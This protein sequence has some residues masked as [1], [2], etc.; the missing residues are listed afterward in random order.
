MKNHIFI[1]GLSL[2]LILSIF[3]CIQQE[4]TTPDVIPKEEINLQKLS[5]EFNIELSTNTKELKQ[6]DISLSGNTFKA[7]LEPVKTFTKLSPAFENMG[8][9]LKTNEFYGFDGGL[10][11]TKEEYKTGYLLGDI[12]IVSEFKKAP[13]DVVYLDTPNAK[14]VVKHSIKIKNNAETIEEISVD[15]EYE[16]QNAKKIIWNNDE[17]I[18]KQGEIIEFNASQNEDAK[19]N[20]I[21]EN[22]D[23]AVIDFID[24]KL[25]KHKAKISY[26]GQ[27]AVI[28]LEVSAVVNPNSEYIIDPYLSYIPYSDIL[29]SQKQGVNFIEIGD[30]NDDNKNDLIL[31]YNNKIEIYYDYLNDIINIDKEFYFNDDSSTILSLDYE[32][33]LLSVGIFPTGVYSFNP[34]E[35]SSTYINKNNAEIDLFDAIGNNFYSSKIKNNLYFASV[36]ISEQKGG[37]LFIS[38]V[39]DF[40]KS[41]IYYSELLGSKT[42]NTEITCN[43]EICCF[44]ISYKGEVYC[45]YNQDII[46]DNQ[47]K[48]YNEAAFLSF[49]GETNLGQQVL[50]NQNNLIL[51]SQD[52]VH[53][54]KDI[55]LLAGNYDI[56]DISLTTYGPKN[57]GKKIIFD[58]FNS[59]LLVLS[60]SGL[61]LLDENDFG[62]INNNPKYNTE[63]LLD[64]IAIAEN[65]N[66]ATYSGEVI[67]LGS[68]FPTLYSSMGVPGSITNCDPSISTTSGLYTLLN[69]VSII[70]AT[71]F[72]FSGYSSSLFIF[73]CDGHTISVDGDGISAIKANNAG[74]FTIQNCNFIVDGSNSNAVDMNSI[75]SLIINNCNFSIQNGGYSD[76]I[77]AVGP[78]TSISTLEAQELNLNLINLQHSNGIN[79]HQTRDININNFNISF[80]SCIDT[81]GLGIDTPS[82]IILENS[83]LNTIGL[84]NE[85]IAGYSIIG[86]SSIE[87]LDVNMNLIG[88]GITGTGFSNSNNILLN[89]SKIEVQGVALSGINIKQGSNNLVNNTNSSAVSNMFVVNV[90]STTTLNPFVISALVNEVVVDGKYNWLYSLNSKNSYD[91]KLQN[92]RFYADCPAPV[93]GSSSGGSVLPWAGYN[94]MAV[95]LN[96]SYIMN[97]TDNII[98][99][100]YCVALTSESSTGKIFNNTIERYSDD[101][102]DFDSQIY[103]P[104]N[105]PQLSAFPII[106][107]Y[108]ISGENLIVYDNEITSSLI[109]VTL[110]SKI[111][112]YNFNFSNNK[113]SNCPAFGF[114]TNVLGN[115]FGPF[116][117]F[118]SNVI[119]SNGIYDIYGVNKSVLTNF[120]TTTCTNY[121][122]LLEGGFGNCNILCY[123][124]PDILNFNLT[125]NCTD[126]VNTNFAGEQTE[127]GDPTQT[128]PSIYSNDTI[129]L[130]TNVTNPSPHDTIALMPCYDLGTN[131]LDLLNT[132]SEALTLPVVPMIG[133]PSIPSV[134]LPS[135][136]TGIIDASTDYLE[137][138]HYYQCFVYLDPQYPIPG[139]E[140]P[141]ESLAFFVENMAPTISVNPTI[142]ESPTGLF[143]DVSSSIASFIDPDGDSVGIP[144]NYTWYINGIED[145][146]TSNFLS[147][148]NYSPGDTITCS[149]SIPDDSNCPQLYSNE[150]N[151]TYFIPAQGWVHVN[152]YP[153]GYTDD[154]YYCDYEYQMPLARQYNIE[155]TWYLFDSWSTGWSSATLIDT[156]TFVSTDTFAHSNANTI[157]DYDLEKC[158]YVACKVNITNLD[159]SYIDYSLAGNSTMAET[160]S[161]IAG[162]GA[163]T[164]I[165]NRPPTL[166]G[167]LTIDTFSTSPDLVLYCNDDLVLFN[168]LDYN[169]VESSRTF[170]WEKDGVL[171][172]ETTDTLTTSIPLDE[173]TYKCCIE[174]SDSIVNG[175]C[176]DSV[177]IC[178]TTYIPPRTI[179]FDVNLSADPIVDHLPSPS[180]CGPINYGDS[181]TDNCAYEDSNFTCTVEN[182]E[183]T[184]LGRVE[185]KDVKIYDEDGNVFV[186]ESGVPYEDIVYYYNEP[187]D[188]EYEGCLENLECQK[189][190]ILYC[191]VTLYDNYGTELETFRS[192]PVQ[193]HNFI[194]EISK[195]EVLV[196]S[197]AVPLEG[198]SIGDY[199][200]TD[201]ESYV[202]KF[203]CVP[204]DVWEDDD[205]TPDYNNDM[206]NKIKYYWEWSPIDTGYINSGSSCTYS[207]YG[208]KC[209]NNQ[210]FSNDIKNELCDLISSRGCS[211]DEISC[212][213]PDEN[214]E[215]HWLP[216]IPMAQLRDYYAF[217][218][219]PNMN[220]T[221]GVCD[222]A[223]LG[224]LTGCAPSIAI[225]CYN[226][227]LYTAEDEEGE[228]RSDLYTAEME[229]LKQCAQG[230][231]QCYELLESCSFVNDYS[232]TGIVYPTSECSSDGLVTI[233]G[234]D[235]TPEGIDWSD[236]WD[237]DRALDTTWN[238]D[239]MGDYEGTY[240][241]WHTSW[242]LRMPD[243][244][245]TTPYMEEA[246]PCNENDYFGEKTELPSFSIWNTYLSDITG[247]FYEKD[248]PN[249]I[250]VRCCIE[251]SDEG[252][253]STYSNSACSEPTCGN[254][255]DC[256]ECAF[257]EEEGENVLRCNSNPR[258]ITGEESS[259]FIYLQ[260]SC[261]KNILWTEP[262]DSCSGVNVS[263]SCYY[264]YT[265]GTAFDIKKQIDLVTGNIIIEQT[266]EVQMCYPCMQYWPMEVDLDFV[267]TDFNDVWGYYYNPWWFR[268][269]LWNS[270]YL[271]KTYG[272]GYSEEFGELPYPD[273]VSL[274]MSAKTYENI[275]IDTPRNIIE[276][277][278]PMTDS[279][280]D[281]SLHEWWAGS[282]GAQQNNTFIS[283]PIGNKN[284]WILRY[285]NSNKTSLSSQFGILEEN[286][287]GRFYATGFKYCN[288]WDEEYIQ[289]I[290]NYNSTTGREIIDSD[291]S[292]AWPST[293]LALLNLPGDEYPWLGRNGS[294]DYITSGTFM[295]E[296][297]LSGLVWNADWSDDYE[298]YGELD[299]DEYGQ[300]RK[301]ARISADYVFGIV[302][303]TTYNK[304]SC[305][306]PDDLNEETCIANFGSSE[307]YCGNENKT[308]DFNSKTCSCNCVC[309]DPN[310]LY[311][312][313]CDAIAEEEGIDRLVL[314]F[315]NVN[316][317]W[318]CVE[319][320]LRRPIIPATGGSG[321]GTGI[322]YSGAEFS[323][324]IEEDTFALFS[325]EDYTYARF[326]PMVDP[327]ELPPCE[328]DSLQTYEDN[329]F[330]SDEYFEKLY[331]Y[332]LSKDEEDLIVN[333][334]AR[335]IVLDCS[336]LDDWDGYR[337]NP[338]Y[339]VANTFWDLDNCVAYEEERIG[340]LLDTNYLEET[341]N[342]GCGFCQ[343]LLI[344]NTAPEIDSLNITMTT[345]A[346]FNCTIDGFIDIDTHPADEIKNAT[347]KWCSDALCTRTYYSE[348]KEGPN[349]YS[350][351]IPYERLPTDASGDPILYVCAQVYD[352]DWDSKQSEEY[353]QAYNSDIPKACAL[354]F[355][356]V[357]DG[358]TFSIGSLINITIN[359]TAT[360]MLSP[361][362]V[363]DVY[364]IDSL[365]NETFLSACVHFSGNIVC[366]RPILDTSSMLPGTYTLIA[367]NSFS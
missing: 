118:D 204:S 205:R 296:N 138:C 310:T 122:F 150:L 267:E 48:N 244:A 272:F 177:S 117:D 187:E 360:S 1:I 321:Y 307:S 188:E 20:I 206:W 340:Y 66:Y 331:E 142:T 75:N 320:S 157:L 366:S 133:I 153:T 58:E 155:V 50:L 247:L 128:I 262:S 295:P 345:S 2:I 365:G 125:A 82:N 180:G 302:Y 170:S 279:E 350:V 175:N 268:D 241:F 328:Y 119:C 68:E 212:W 361:E 9:T 224:G 65:G 184:G 349:P 324:V 179:E 106:N 189:G 355:V 134:S 136:S 319:P 27:K 195:P 364:L 83:N 231:R 69:D 127:P 15:L 102:T 343:G 21:L 323:S 18:L 318:R 223:S 304:I 74:T 131:P 17:Y 210:C 148:S 166:T 233:A 234:F 111:D 149:V 54:I 271:P 185:T 132:N 220:V 183:Y 36:P 90:P 199:D 312:P 141:E 275:T 31:A 197:E 108:D 174:V 61:H 194:P 123:D 77:K 222:W 261:N 342:E 308:W 313:D 49:S 107:N 344:N 85:Q 57:Y 78:T 4:P 334:E 289:D 228:C 135:D 33:G 248:K 290:I 362:K 238:Y 190:D 322:H 47:Y 277:C 351:F 341:E 316:C 76:G 114:S 326:D 53:V 162:Q 303:N 96:N 25:E 60:N 297:S 357:S 264:N 208:D 84:L 327:E 160:A 59:Q 92:N 146:L 227:I 292:N 254:Y 251:Q 8:F 163:P 284:M 192:N 113:I 252:F 42:T 348:T 294:S 330:V 43:E 171:L 232:G 255:L 158:H 35:L 130:N 276:P 28:I 22:G 221:Y 250:P 263:Y 291:Y 314:N 309:K 356:E 169:D 172:D 103:A 242:Y 139:C 99:S 305:E 216:F 156:N 94:T 201:L 30:V 44:G 336:A 257:Y 282:Y 358:D 363:G 243:I 339:C 300:C 34:N 346:S 159:G 3:G 98:L 14:E 62:N 6:E 140:S 236:P 211:N 239:C 154:I 359:T 93:S 71:C 104:A 105:Q 246:Y 45:V 73:D 203:V 26:D 353:C 219:I 137:S 19:I 115:V 64:K 89:N 100:Q 7:E 95:R 311:K 215:D 46:F 86:G 347:F 147:N 39:P 186:E 161:P 143:C 283:N 87:I 269:M 281:V 121:N 280:C 287:V 265:N 109:G 70:D 11:Y 167:Y 367:N 259:C 315:D 278:D 91:L 240:R 317:K 249:G 245:Y 173:A 120:I 178:N 151:A 230:T 37:I 270:S 273:K 38:Q 110:D 298:Q 274:D 207:E 5:D 299:C 325:D 80:D 88:G 63:D 191:N 116:T 41:A 182:I 266:D 56:K 144:I 165:I 288:Q 67:Y 329:C 51:S 285:E 333:Q 258:C 81:S 301:H 293:E 24:L 40:Q 202:G 10:E 354:D 29:N 256:G 260:D 226:G 209:S 253:E 16:V 332:T 217:D 176:K 198:I 200:E 152:P 214:N 196:I 12:S 101:I 286:I 352:T 97:I 338:N 145:G 213:G 229:L 164:Q 72:E 129:C 112:K 32:N 335:D 181:R 79:I 225:E 237:I 168:D 13:K 193:I 126:Y 306:C 55:N 218:F 235:L 337:I 23:K 52:Q 124:C